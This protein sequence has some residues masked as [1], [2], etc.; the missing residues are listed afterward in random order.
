MKL[1]KRLMAKA[2]HSDVKMRDCNDVFK[3]LKMLDRIERKSKK[4]TLKFD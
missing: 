4:S 3:F 2:H 1:P